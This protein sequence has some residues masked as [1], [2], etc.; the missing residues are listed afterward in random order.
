MTFQW[1]HLVYS[2]ATEVSSEVSVQI[3]KGAP[4]TPCGS[5]ESPL[6]YTLVP[7][8]W[9]RKKSTLPAPPIGTP[10]YPLPYIMSSRTHV[11]SWLH[12]FY[13]WSL[14]EPVLRF[15]YDDK[16]QAFKIHWKT[17]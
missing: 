15:G 8:R 12:Y 2:V 3:T 1:L 9:I 5:Q 10:N 7:T 14:Y 17:L 16:P 6:L 11:G 4:L 13:G